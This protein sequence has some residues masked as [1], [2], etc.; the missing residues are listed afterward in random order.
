M[1]TVSVDHLFIDIQFAKAKGEA[2][3]VAVV[4]TDSHGKI[5]RGAANSGDLIAALAAIDTM[6]APYSAP[7][8]VVACGA[9][10]KRTA[11]REACA[12]E[13]TED[14]FH[15]RAWLDFGQVAWPLALAE[16]VPNRSLETV[17]EHFRITRTH[18]GTLR[19][20]CAYLVAVYWAMARSYRTAL[21]AENAVTR[22]AE[23]YGGEAI[24]SLRRLVGI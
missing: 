3:A 23:K 11:L 18:E 4:R 19:G 1:V 7:Y 15:G 24:N 12:R 21:T 10:A 5:L 13:K 6:V 2:F 16:L 22:V 14:P 8:I 17:G 20:D 9:D